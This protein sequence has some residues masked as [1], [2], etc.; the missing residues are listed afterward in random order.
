MGRAR[1][2][3]EKSVKAAHLV[4]GFE[5]PLQELNA[6]LF[7]LC[8]RPRFRRTLFAQFLF[9]FVTFPFR[10]ALLARGGVGDEAGMVSVLLNSL[11]EDVSEQ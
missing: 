8:A 7:E 2:T 1:Q 10:L 4:E 5:P 3:R 9:A 6:G 11:I